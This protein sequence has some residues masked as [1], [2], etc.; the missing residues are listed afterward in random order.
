M[1]VT[2]NIKPNRRNKWVARKVL[3]GLSE[4]QYGQLSR[5]VSDRQEKNPR[6]TAS[7]VIQEAITNLY[8]QT[9]GFDGE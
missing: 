9:Y 1:E 2:P 4:K 8:N 5:L 3:T 6:E 7:S